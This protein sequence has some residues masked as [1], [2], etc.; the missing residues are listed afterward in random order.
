[1]SPHTFCDIESYYISFI[2]R[3]KKCLY[4]S[5]L[6]VS[7]WFVECAIKCTGQILPIYMNVRPTEKIKKPSISLYLIAQ[8]GG[9]RQEYGEN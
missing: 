2:I 5:F 8:I 3:D 1:M 4:V 9:S 7:T 6:H